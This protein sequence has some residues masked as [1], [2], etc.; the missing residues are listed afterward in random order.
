M[1]GF[2][3][4]LLYGLAG[5][6]CY[7]GLHHLLVAC[8]RPVQR[9][10][11]LFALLC[12]AVAF[13]V[14]AKAGAYH[15]DSAQAL[16]ALRR[17]EASWGLTFFALLPWFVAE[18]TGIR[19]RGLLAALSGIFMVVLA[20]N[21]V[22]PYGGQF[23]ELPRLE[24]MTLPWG[25][26][27][28]DLRV[29][30]R[31]PWHNAAWV[32]I[33]L[34]FAYGFYACTRQYRGGAKARAL[35]LTLALALVGAFAFVNWLTN[36]GVIRFT[37]TAEF[38]FLSLVIVM[39]L[40]LTRELREGERR[41]RAVLDHVPAAVYIK[42]PQGRY[43]LINREYEQLFGVTNASVAGKVDADLFPA[44]QAA[45]FRA[46]DR[47]VLENREPLAS[48]EVVDRDDEA[49]TRYSLKFPLFYPDGTPYAVCGVSTDITERK[50][51]EE[52]F[53]LAVEASPNGIVMVNRDGQIVLVN[54]RTEKLFGYTREELIGQ[55][56]EILVPERFR[57]YHPAHRAGYFAAPRT[58][59]MGG[60]RDLFARRKDG[61]EFLVEIGLNPIRSNEGL[62]V[63]TAIVDITERKRAESELQQHQRALAHVARVSTL[64]ELSASLA[65]ELN[66][67]LAAI[68]SNAQAGLRFLD[69][70]NADLQEIREILQDI[71][72]DD[73]R[74]SGVI[75]GLRSL[76]RRQETQ[77][78]RIDLAE[79]LEQVQELLHSELVAR[80]VQV[81][82]DLEASCTVLA[83][84]AQIQ[85]V[86]LNL[87]MNAVEAMEGQAA[88][89]HRLELSL[90][91]RDE[92]EV[93]VAVRDSGKGIPADALA[94]VFDPFWTTKSQGMGLGLGICR[95]IIESHGGKI[96]VERNAAQGVTFYFK[97]P[98]LL[99]QDASVKRQAQSSI[100]GV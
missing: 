46:D 56:V 77:R 100:R 6:C 34:V 55:P 85:Q 58:R 44:E 36:H 76:T 92:A 5:V 30:Q 93:Q 16:V 8:R 2:L 45:V 27:V 13:H 89:Q 19:P 4:P 75:S 82:T 9:T 72:R 66:Q 14:V 32:G 57:D 1:N 40:G 20:A 31:T 26:H 17:W 95:S 15:A 83:D 60:G 42:D 38:G 52:K 99:A 70:G 87:M 51:A 41:L 3:I 63:L 35:T 78:E 54:V 84:R 97:L 22:L 62:F 65:H 74:A 24:Y 7:A 21:L 50:Q 12:L 86:V 94:K 98:A 71:A 39:S 69:Q 23:A 59:P 61:S 37:H 49:R 68:L 90:L 25:E 96:W 81:E 80:R 47:R 10:H 91:H 11:L 53:R 73:K 67:P 88:G 64:G 33:A 28:V 43:L 29:H 48:E 79:V 18:Y